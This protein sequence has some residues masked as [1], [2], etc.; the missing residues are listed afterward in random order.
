MRK[1]ELLD[2]YIS[3][4]NKVK[5]YKKAESLV[6]EIITIYQPEIPSIKDSLILG[7][8]NM[9]N[10]HNPKGSYL[11]DLRIL[12]LKLGNYRANIELEE[13]REKRKLEALQ[14]QKSLIINNT[15]NNANTNTVTLD[16]T[17]DQARERIENMS[18]LKDSEI[19]EILKKVDE[20]EKIVQSKD[21]KTKKWENAKGII[22]WVADKGVDVGIALLPLLLQIQ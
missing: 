9:E 22:K 15:N 2:N 14:I 10:I 3:L 4:C 16:I 18:S 17:F 7:R 1:I 11:E 12:A 13:E 8:V 21:K 6:N 5:D 20:L 19:K